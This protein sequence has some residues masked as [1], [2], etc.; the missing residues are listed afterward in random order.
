MSNGLAEKAVDIAK[1]IMLKCAETGTHCLDGLREYNNTP[2]FG[3]KES[4]A[5]RVYPGTDGA[6]VH[7]AGRD[8]R[9]LWQGWVRVQTKKSWSWRHFA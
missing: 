6:C 2:L 5:Q 8:E 3:M 9:H 4:P 1:R 7:P